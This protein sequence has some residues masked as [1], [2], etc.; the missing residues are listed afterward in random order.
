[1]RLYCLEAAI[2]LGMKSVIG[3][4]YQD[5]PRT[6]LM[7]R[8]GYELKPVARSEDSEHRYIS[9][10]LFAYLHL[11]SSGHTAIETLRAQVGT[12]ER[13]VAWTGVPLMAVLQFNLALSNQASSSSSSLNSSA[14][15][16][17]VDFGEA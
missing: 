11:K 17:R 12:A 13:K 3:I 6:R 16:T 8:L 15:E 14:S 10:C 5:A 4:V 1:M 7:V 9:Q 2:A